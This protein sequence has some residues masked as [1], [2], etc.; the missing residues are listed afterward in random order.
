M[1]IDDFLQRFPLLGAEVSGAWCAASVGNLYHMEMWV[2]E[3]NVSGGK[4]V[5]EDGERTHLDGLLSRI[6]TKGYA[7]A[8][9]VALKRAEFAA[10]VDDPTEVVTYLQ[11]AITYAGIAPVDISDR[12]EAF[13]SNYPRYKLLSEF[14]GRHLPL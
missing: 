10:D 6:K 2:D 5:L 14:R 11:L 7:K 12:L 13:A 9:D 3:A 4:I 8:A 1:A